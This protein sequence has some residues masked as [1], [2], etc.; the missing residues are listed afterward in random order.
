[1]LF[2]IF[3]NMSNSFY[4]TAG[5]NQLRAPAFSANYGFSAPHPTFNS[6]W[7]SQSSMATEDS[8]AFQDFYGGYGPDPFFDS[9]LEPW[10]SSANDPPGD[11]IAQ[12]PPQQETTPPPL[13]DRAETTSLSD[14]LSHVKNLEQR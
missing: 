5:S 2:N 9:A 8:A 3:R 6:F 13:D 14:L 4:H 1:M 11:Y 7:G 10:E 12:V